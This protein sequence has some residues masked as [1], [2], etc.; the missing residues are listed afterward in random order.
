MNIQILVVSKTPPQPCEQI[1]PLSFES[2]IKNVRPK[3]AVI[4]KKIPDDFS[5]SKNIP[6]VSY[7]LWK[8]PIFYVILNDILVFW[9][10]K[11]CVLCVR[12]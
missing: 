1:F 4:V 8:I 5:R 11:M 3:E 7:L 9:K 6:I 10:Y 2:L 12:R